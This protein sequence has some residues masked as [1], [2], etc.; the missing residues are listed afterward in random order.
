MNTRLPYDMQMAMQNELDSMYMD[1][2]SQIAIPQ[3]LSPTAVPIQDHVSAVAAAMPAFLQQQEQ[4]KAAETARADQQHKNIA[5]G[6]LT[7][8]GG[9]NLAKPMATPG[10]EVPPPAPQAPSFGPTQ[11][12]ALPIDT[13]LPGGTPT[14]A[15]V[16]LSNNM[17]N[18][19][20]VGN[21][22]PGANPTW[23]DNAK[24]K[25]GTAWDN[26]KANGQASFDASLPGKGYDWLKQNM[27]GW[28][29]YI[30]Q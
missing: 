21:T 25:V 29:N 1:P 12:L 2:L 28:A 9:A 3:Q 6:V 23:W 20:Y 14:A 19:E 7:L 11:P 16:E 15:G 4:R 26:Y 27:P 24:A 13:S 8:A 30:G 18:P 22:A 10:E 5:A 17:K